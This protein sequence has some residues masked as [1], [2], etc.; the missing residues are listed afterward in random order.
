MIRFHLIRMN[1]KLDSNQSYQ[2]ER[3]QKY[4]HMVQSILENTMMDWKN[5]VSISSMQMNTIFQAR[6][7][8]LNVIHAM[9]SI[10]K[11]Q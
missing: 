2:L 4:L 1:V 6:D 10:L 3:P 9:E 7:S 8:M 5:M 11:F